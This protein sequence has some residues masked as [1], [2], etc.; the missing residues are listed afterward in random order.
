MK[1]YTYMNHGRWLVMCPKCGNEF[2]VS[3]ETKTMICFVCHPG[4]MANSNERVETE[5]PISHTKQVIWRTVPDYELRERAKIEVI[6]SKEEYEIVF[7]DEA[8]EIEKSVSG[9]DGN[10]QNWYPDRKEIRL[11]YPKASA[12]GQT[13]KQLKAEVS[14]GL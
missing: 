10:W 12:Y 2:K 1:T 6:K 14:H 13:V 8:E 3:R 9:K 11:K 7:P 4:I 5:S